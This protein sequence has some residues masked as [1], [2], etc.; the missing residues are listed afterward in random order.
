MLCSPVDLRQGAE[1]IHQL[2]FELLLLLVAESLFTEQGMD[3][4]LQGPVAGR[5][6]GQGRPHFSV[7]CQ[8]VSFGLAESREGFQIGFLQL[9]YG[10]VLRSIHGRKF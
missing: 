4:V 5:S 10:F 3:S 8:E 2:S 9:E 6:L 1:G 7:H